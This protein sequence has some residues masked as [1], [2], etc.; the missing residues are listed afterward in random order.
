MQSDLGFGVQG[1]RFGF[2][3]IH[4]RGSEYLESRGN[5]INRLMTGMTVIWLL[6]VIS[7]LTESS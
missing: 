1:L 3:A 6:G 4:A 5:L 2:S 7:I